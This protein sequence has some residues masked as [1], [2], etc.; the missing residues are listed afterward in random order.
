MLALNSAAKAVWSEG[1]GPAYEI[2]LNDGQPCKAGHIG[3]STRN[4]RTVSN[5]LSPITGYAVDE[6]SEKRL[7]P[8]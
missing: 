5:L 7:A 1:T 8:G 3:L 4:D 6:E 2:Y